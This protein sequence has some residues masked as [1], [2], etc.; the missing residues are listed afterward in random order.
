ML[1]RLPDGTQVNPEMVA[2]VR[3]WP[4]LGDAQV[5]DRIT[6]EYGAGGVVSLQGGAELRDAVAELIQAGCY[7]ARSA[8]GR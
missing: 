3:H 1:V 6:V 7:E 4:A 8:G 5:G 2:A